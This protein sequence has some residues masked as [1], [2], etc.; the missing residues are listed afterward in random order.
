MTKL[1]ICGIK[2]IL[3]AEQIS[4]L[5]QIDYLGLIFAQSV[6]KVDEKTAIKLSQ[7]IHKNHKKVVG[8][9]VD[10]SLEFILKIAQNAE[11]DGVQIHRRIAQKDFEI[12][13]KNK[14]FVW[15]VISVGEN[16]QM[17]S[18]IYAD[19][20]LFDTKGKFKGGNGISFDWNLLKDYK[21]KFGI[22]GGIGA[23]NVREAKALNPTLIDVNSKVENSQGLKE[24]AKIKDLIKE[25]QK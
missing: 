12:L 3:N 25:F 7:I 8:V 18:Q 15:Q 24:L 21:Q 22:A 14:L 16:L 11:L 6:R 1:K 10:E 13:Q 23:H 20:T 2:D 5:E 9:F 19:M 4:G 17:P